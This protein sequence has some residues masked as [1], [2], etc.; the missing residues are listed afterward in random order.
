M[1][2]ETE[3][4]GT[5]VFEAD[6]LEAAV[7]A[8]ARGELVVYPTE[9][10]YGLGANA[11][12][13]DAVRRVFAAKER[14]R[15]KPLSMAVESVSAVEEYVPVTDQER[16]FMQ[17]FLPG[18]VTVVVSASEEIPSELLGGR[19]RVG[20]RVPDNEIALKLLSRTPPLTA[21]SANI[22]GAESAR[23]IPELD[24]EIRAD[25]AIVI[26]GGRTPGGGSTVVDVEREQVHRRG[27]LSDQI[28]EWLATQ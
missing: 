2:E 27:P 18:P 15:S 13:E 4:N 20:I 17:E 5:A 28:T 26:D 23:S 25:A 22:S 21:T 12:D 19:E 14:D 11:L 7:N 9:T 3:L 1:T 24:E 8:I 16:E 10:V 6:Q